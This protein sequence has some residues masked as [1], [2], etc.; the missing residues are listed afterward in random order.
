LPIIESIV[1]QHAEEA[2]FLWLLRDLAVA[3]PHYSLQDV[4][5]LDERVE[6]HID[7]LRVAGDPGWRL[8]AE[9]LQQQ[10]SGEV[11]AAAV[12]AFDGSA[13]ERLRQV[14]VAVE[15]APETVRGLISA[16]GWIGP[17]R[18]KGKISALLGS[19]SPLWRGVGIAA[20]AV[21]RVDCGEHLAKAIEDADINLRRRALRTAGE[22]GRADLLPAVKGQLQQDD[23]G[24]AF[25]AAWSAVLLG[26]RAEGVDSLKSLALTDGPLSTRAIQT[27]LPV[28]DSSAS[29][30]WLKAL[31]G[32]SDRRRDLIIGCGA[33]GDP[34]YVPWLIQQMTE[35]PASARIAGEAFSMITGADLAYLD[36]DGDQ[37]DGFEAGPTESPADENVSMDP[38][39]DLPWPDPTRIQAWWGANAGRFSAGSRYLAGDPITASN[40]KGVLKMG[41]QRQR[42]AAAL[43]LALMQADAPLF[44]TRAPGRRQQAL[45]A[46]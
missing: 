31:A 39:E 37:P 15:S 27:L 8:C 14:Y 16:I 13:S 46:Q 20:C 1:S 26:D 4:A 2:A 12:I 45:L 24:C 6:A 5:D 23:P 17:D 3:A 43:E 7:G 38:D 10:E 42:I 34:A 28:L 35:A 30:A 18:L 33:R 36:L 21:H 22:T 40:C 11:F 29:A 44:E 32:A 25:W 9:G 19:E 41:M